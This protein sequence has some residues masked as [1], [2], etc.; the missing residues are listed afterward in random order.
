MTAPFGTSLGRI[1]VWPRVV[2]AW[3]AVAYVRIILL[4]NAHGCGLIEARL[5]SWG[6]S[7]SHVGKPMPALPINANKRW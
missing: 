1:G 2:G 7:R 3:L 5:V 6:E 4:W